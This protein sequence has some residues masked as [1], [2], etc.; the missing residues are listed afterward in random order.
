MTIMT[1]QTDHDAKVREI[2]RPFEGTKEY[3]SI[4]QRMQRIVRCIIEK[5]DIIAYMADTAK[6]Y[7]KDPWKM[8]MAMKACE[9]MLPIPSDSDPYWTSDQE[10]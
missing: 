10:D 3:P 4:V 1:E 6:R 8:E 7:S 2:C 5:E 9:I